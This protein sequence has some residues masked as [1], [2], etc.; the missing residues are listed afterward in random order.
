MTTINWV[1]YHVK[2]HHSILP[3]DRQAKLNHEMDLLCKSFW[4]L[5]LTTERIWFQLQWQVAS[6]NRRISSNIAGTICEQCNIFRA[7]QYWDNKHK[8]M[9]QNT[10]WNAMAA[11]NKKMGNG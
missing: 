5:R 10:N 7:E 1:P 9:V 3:L 6:N 2:G 11:A 8:T 4:M